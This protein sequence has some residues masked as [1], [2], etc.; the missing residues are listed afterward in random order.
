MIPEFVT[1]QASVCPEFVTPQ[2]SV[3]PEFVTLQASVC[4]EFV[5]LQASVC[6]EFITLQASV[7]IIF[8]LGTA[9]STAV[10][11]PINLIH[12]KRFISECRLR[13]EE[14]ECVNPFDNSKEWV[15]LVIS[16]NYS[17]RLS[18]IVYY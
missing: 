4:P 9:S 2:A 1:P 15:L 8:I 12:I 7:F 3:C 16:K 17:L 14:C 6:P 10:E 18:F 13:I 5:T 11:M